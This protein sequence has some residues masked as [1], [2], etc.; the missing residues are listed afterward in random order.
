MINSKTFV[1]TAFVPVE[2][3]NNQ[4]VISTD[5]AQLDEDV[6]FDYLAN[7]SYWWADLTR[8]KLNRYLQYSLCFGVYEGERQVGF[9]RVVTDYTTFAYLGDVFILPSHQGHGL[10]KWLVACILQ[11][12]ELQSLR[13]WT[14]N[15]RDAHTLYERFGFQNDPKPENYLVYRPNEVTRD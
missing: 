13:K 4:Y 6:I 15:T 9:A 7:E 3:K 11:H 1:S 10:G 14:L 2:Y 12:P 5:S 8:E